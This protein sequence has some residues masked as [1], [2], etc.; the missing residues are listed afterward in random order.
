[1]SSEQGFRF[2][3]VSCNLSSHQNEAGHFVF[4]L[5]TPH[6]CKEYSQK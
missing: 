3:S 5:H 6:G 4:Y 1:M 2:D